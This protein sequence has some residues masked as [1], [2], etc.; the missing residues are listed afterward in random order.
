VVLHILNKWLEVFAQRNC[1]RIDKTL[2]P[3]VPPASTQAEPYVPLFVSAQYLTIPLLQTSPWA[4]SR[5]DAKRNN[6]KA[7]ADENCEVMSSG[8]LSK[9]GQ[10]AQKRMTRDFQFSEIDRIRVRSIK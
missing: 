4:L 2:L 1:P 8:G 7:I 3:E 9:C 10:Y 5:N 6:Q